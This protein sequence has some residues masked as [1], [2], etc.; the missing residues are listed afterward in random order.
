MADGQ[1]AADGGGTMQRRLWRTLGV[2]VAAVVMV[3]GAGEAGGLLAGQSSTVSS[4][5]TSVTAVVLDLQEGSADVIAGS[6][7]AVVLT[8]QLNW[9]LRRP[10]VEQT[11][12]GHTLRISVS[13]T[14]ILGIGE[15]GCSVALDLQVPAATAVTVRMTSG[16][17]RIAG[18]SGALDLRGTSGELDLDRDSGPIDARL[19]SGRISGMRLASAGVR[20]STDSGQTDLA[21]A[22]PPD[23]LTLACDSGSVR[24]TVPPGSTYRVS[25]RSAGDAPRIAPL[26]ADSGSPRT[27][28][29]SAGSGT[30]TLGFTPG[31]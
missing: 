1:P 13:C 2:L 25:A 16:Y 31:D 14:R 20:A 21:F 3:I 27:I 30:V 9:T 10:R 5:Y 18:L 6:D 26:L 28:T 29:A 24:A 8:P 11:L 23:Q 15:P 19:T 17:G 7:D 4:R 12:D 22:Q